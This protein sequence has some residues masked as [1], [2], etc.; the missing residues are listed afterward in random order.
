MHVMMQALEGCG[1]PFLPYGL[2]VM[3]TFTE[4]TAQSK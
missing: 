2:S 1:G 3:N 4:M